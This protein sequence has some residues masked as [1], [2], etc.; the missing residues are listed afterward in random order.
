MIPRYLP[1][2]AL[3]ARLQAAGDAH[4][5]AATAL[6]AQL[7][8]GQ[9]FAGRLAVAALRDGLN[10]YFKDLARKAGPAEVAMSAQIC[11]LVPLA[12]REAGLVP[13]FV[14]IAPDRPVPSGQQ[15]AAALGASVRGV[16]VAPL[17]GHLGESSDAL[18]AALG[19]RSLLLDLA[20]GLG[21]R[22][23]DTLLARAN[24]VGY[25]FG[26]GKGVDTGGGLLLTRTTVHV[27]GG[28]K[29]SLGAGAIARSAALRAIVACG[30]YSAGARLV[31]RAAEAKPE[32]FDP[33]VREL[34]GDWVYNWWKRRL[35][36]FLEEVELA[37]TRAVE[38]RGRLGSHPALAY[39][40]SCFSPDAT[41]LRQVVRLAEPGRRNAT[42]ERLRRSGIDCARAGEPLPSQYL[43]GERGDYPCAIRFLSDSIRLPFLGR[44]SERQFMYFSD[45][46]ERA[47]D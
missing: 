42:L 22:G 9:V 37:R 14:D 3:R 31:E 15:L 18:I 26:V 16:V 24:A 1:A 39:A 19:E 41:H 13:H 35:A 11:P 17:Y 44:L 27:D 40:D 30:L 4:A 38:L 7:A 34:E 36:P 23:V 32:D 5:E 33:R 12:A 6:I 28:R 46:L 43:P 20:Q 2:V 10:A 8:P 29:A 21:L 47:L 45:A 25:S